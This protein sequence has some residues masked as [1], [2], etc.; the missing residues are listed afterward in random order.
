VSQLHLFM[1]A[2]IRE[3][4][5]DSIEKVDL[6]MLEV[7]GNISVLS[8]NFK[9]KTRKKRIRKPLGNYQ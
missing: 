4:G 9:T 1:T 7:D 8:E 5:V 2:A 6:A 3:H